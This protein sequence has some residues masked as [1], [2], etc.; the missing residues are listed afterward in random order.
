MR[1]PESSSNPLSNLFLNLLLKRLRKLA[2]GCPAANPEN[3]GV[4]WRQSSNAPRRTPVF[5]IENSTELPE[6]SIAILVGS[7]TQFLTN[8]AT[9]CG[10][11]ANHG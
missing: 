6:R 5:V 10:L 1:K 2:N 11:G 8:N 3:L 4:R 9:A 7:E